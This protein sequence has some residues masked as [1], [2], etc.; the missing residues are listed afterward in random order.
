M[1]R[2]RSTTKPKREPIPLSIFY[3][4][5]IGERGR[6]TITSYHEVKYF[7]DWGPNPTCEVQGRFLPEHDLW[8]RLD[9]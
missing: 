6:T 7:I 1:S 5:D 9:D 8:T 4:P 2:A 3:Y